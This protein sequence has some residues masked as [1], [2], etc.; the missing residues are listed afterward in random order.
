MTDNTTYLERD[1]LREWVFQQVRL[2]P[3]VEFDTLRIIAHKEQVIPKCVHPYGPFHWRKIDRALQWLRKN[4]RITFDRPKKGWVICECK[5]SCPDGDCDHVWD[6]PEEIER[7][8]NGNVKSASS[9]CSK[10]GMSAMSH[11][12]WVC[13]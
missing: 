13:P 9:T 7:Y 10:C 6:G 1:D 8:E 3:W 2:R 4:G 11:D 12:V 5:C